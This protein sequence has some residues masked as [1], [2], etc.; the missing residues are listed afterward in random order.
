MTVAEM[1]PHGATEAIPPACEMCG[2][3]TKIVLD[4]ATLRMGEGDNS[5]SVT[6]AKFRKELH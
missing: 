1:F 4:A 5:A 3:Q 6:P 2:A